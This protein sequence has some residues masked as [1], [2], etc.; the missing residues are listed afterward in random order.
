MP[1]QHPCSIHLRH[2][3][4]HV[5]I[6]SHG[7]CWLTVN[8]LKCLMNLETFCWKTRKTSPSIVLV[9]YWVQFLQLSFCNFKLSLILKRHAQKISMTFQNTTM[10]IEHLISKYLIKYCVLLSTRELIVC[11][12]RIAND[13]GVLCIL[14]GDIPYWRINLS[15]TQKVL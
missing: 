1:L 11:G 8:Q 2:A 4:R 15:I 14:L 13:V 12:E 7:L 10:T 3:I 9:K 6:E 5:I